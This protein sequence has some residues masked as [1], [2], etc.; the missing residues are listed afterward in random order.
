MVL[1]VFYRGMYRIET[2]EVAMECNVGSSDK[3][4]RWIVGLCLISMIFWVHGPWR[5]IGL[6]GFAPI[7][8]ASVNFCPLYKVIGISTAK[9]QKEP[10]PEEKK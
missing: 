5:W 3:I 6:I 2:E 10:G 1:L 9:K 8:T 7:F 4:I